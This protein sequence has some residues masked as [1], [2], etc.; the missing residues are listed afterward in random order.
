MAALKAK[1]TLSRLTCP[2][3]DP[4]D[5]NDYADEYCQDAGYSN[6]EDVDYD[7]DDGKCIN[8]G[9]DGPY[10]GDGRG[11]TSEKA[12]ADE[13]VRRSLGPMPESY[14]DW[15]SL[16]AA[17]TA[18]AGA[19]VAGTAV[20]A[21]TDGAS[22]AHGYP[23]GA[24]AGAGAGAHSHFHGLST[25]LVGDLIPPYPGLLSNNDDASRHDE[26]S[27]HGRAHGGAARRPATAMPLTRAH[28]AA[29]AASQLPKSPVSGNLNASPV[30]QPGHLLA[31]SASPQAGVLP[32]P[33]TARRL[34][35]GFTAHS[36]AL[37][38]QPPA[39]GLGS[40]QA[41]VDG[42]RRPRPSSYY[43]PRPRSPVAVAAAAVIAATT[44]ATTAAAAAATAGTGVDADV[45]VVDVRKPVS[46]CMGNWEHGLYTV[47][48]DPLARAHT[49]GAWG[50]GRA[51]VRAHDGGGT[52]LG[53]R[54]RDA[55][56]PPLPE[57]SSNS[58][59]AEKDTDDGAGDVDAAPAARSSKKKGGLQQQSMYSEPQYLWEPWRPPPLP[60]A[61]VPGDAN[62]RS[63]GAAPAAAA[64]AGAASHGA[65]KDRV[66]PLRKR[67]LREGARHAAEA[68]ERERVAR[69]LQIRPPRE[70]V[71]PHA[72]SLKGEPI[73]YYCRSLGKD[74]GSKKTSGAE[75]GKESGADGQTHNPLFQAR[76]QAGSGPCKL[77]GATLGL[78]RR[79][80]YEESVLR[81]L[82]A[83]A[84]ER[85]LSVL[86]AQE[87]QQF[88]DTSNEHN[89]PLYAEASP[90]G[91]K[92]PSKPP[93]KYPGCEGSGVW[94]PTPPRNSG[95]ASERVPLSVTSNDDR[96]NNSTHALVPV[97]DGTSGG[98]LAKSA[99][100]A[101]VERSGN[102]DANA[103]SA[104]VHTHTVRHNMP[105]RSNMNDNGP[106][107]GSIAATVASR[108]STDV[109]MGAG[110][111]GGGFD[112]YSS[113][114]Q[115]NSTQLTMAQQ[116]RIA[117][118]QQQTH[119][120][121]V[122][123]SEQQRVP[124]YMQ[125]QQRSVRMQLRPHTA[126]P[127]AAR[128]NRFIEHR[129]SQRQE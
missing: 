55:L 9:A 74:M 72:G 61:L 41:L 60:P 107:H 67:A 17:A 84:D 35:D 70:E 38:A 80:E 68:P 44:L 56:V 92:Y 123:D 57:S 91:S 8:G 79:L 50:G 120:N 20:A 65:A 115:F 53:T 108:N 7:D 66:D 5:Y 43:E 52:V 87:Q 34:D 4:V 106:L 129:I 90:R 2:V 54:V 1:R 63:G 47:P 114:S 49:Q 46:V 14:Q 64:A 45:H 112:R 127:A 103:P 76:P 16:A 104:Y 59:G 73:R 30:R 126:A 62:A 118:Q 32:R 28:E 88:G 75:M 3:P 40:F 13:L 83:Q 105:A 93:S 26:H 99:T 22:D 31:P 128:H 119:Q 125:P 124:R 27:A 39:R 111:A 100:I 10:Y 37:A 48:A 25:S 81:A 121:D 21:D 85:A 97:D 117:M 110:A 58:K 77:D 95:W 29:V 51:V 11:L 101:A 89:V 15:V 18:A 109:V 102:V 86:T 78:V 36:G 82:A 94:L 71:K 96:L 116:R 6:T 23:P 33:S 98:D 12:A 69:A 113:N 24:G 42:Q 19:A 122:G